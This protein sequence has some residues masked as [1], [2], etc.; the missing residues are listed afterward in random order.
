MEYNYYIS[1]GRVTLILVGSNLTTPI[2]SIALTLLFRVI[3]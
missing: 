3:E 2:E 1:V